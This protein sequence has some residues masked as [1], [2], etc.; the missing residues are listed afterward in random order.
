MNGKTQR[1]HEKILKSEIGTIRK[2]GKERLKIAVVYPNT[3]HVGMSNLGF[4]TVYRLL[5]AL[6]DVVCERAFL[7][8]R[9]TPRSGRITTIESQKPLNNYDIVAFSISFENDFPHILEILAQAAL[10]L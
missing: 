2:T 5:N 6:E 1:P 4:Q 3:Y 9:Q 7:P 8:D 10:P